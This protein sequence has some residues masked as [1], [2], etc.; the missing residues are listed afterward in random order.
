MKPH[1]F[2]IFDDADYSRHGSLDRVPANVSLL[3]SAPGTKTQLSN[4]GFK[5]HAPSQH[6]AIENFQPPSYYENYVMTATYSDKMQS[7]QRS[8][9]EKLVNLHEGP[10]GPQSFVEIGCGDGSFMK[11]ARQRVP[12]VLGIEPSRRFADEAVREGFEV[13]VGYVG[14]AVPL[15]AER[16]DSFA[17]RQVFEHL[18]DPCDVLIGIRQILNPGAVGL[19][20][21]PNGQRALRLKRFFEFFPDHVNYYSVN[22]LVAL[23]SDAGFNVTGC[24]E[25]FD[26]DYLEL[27]LRNEPAVESWFGEMVSHREQ[28]CSDLSNKVADLASHG[29]RVAI[30][31]CGA[32]TLSI[33]A[34]SPTE[35]FPRIRGVID[36][37]PHKHGRYV[38]NT[39]IPIVSPEEGIALRPDVVLILALSYREEIAASVRQRIPCCRSILTLDDHG[40]ITE[41]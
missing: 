4:I 32:K 1:A 40:R 5:W 9:L 7:L 8:Q 34:A 36:S 6:I 37:D 26:G 16:F 35:L 20:E 12:R 19:I 39:A 30:W 41:L 10:H 13:L 23:A 17:S 21:V 27:W 33:L 22:S 2:P 14:A 31:G 28:V 3:T 15:T 24:H 11:Y 38:P 25:A 18:P 29:S